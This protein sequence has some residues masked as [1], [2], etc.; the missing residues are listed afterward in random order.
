MYARYNSNLT[1]NGLGAF[2]RVLCMVLAFIAL[3]A[4]IVF[5]LFIMPKI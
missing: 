5:V 1:D 4:L 2:I 3:L